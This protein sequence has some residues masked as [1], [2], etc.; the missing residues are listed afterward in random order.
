MRTCGVAALIAEYFWR[1]LDI[2]RLSTSDWPVSINTSTTDL[3]LLHHTQLVYGQSP[4]R[5]ANATVYAAT[6]PELSG[7]LSNANMASICFAH[8]EAA[9]SDPDNNFVAGKPFKYIGADTDH[10]CELSL[11]GA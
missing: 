10:P 4:D 7:A 6:A 1:A 3:T 11:H 5:A 9:R 8:T 2:H